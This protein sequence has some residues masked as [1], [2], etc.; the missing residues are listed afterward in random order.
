MPN[1]N[2]LSD[3]KRMLDAE[4]FADFDMETSDKKVIKAHKGVL[5]SRS[6]VF[7]GMLSSGMKETKYNI[8]KVPEDSVVMEEVLRFIYGANEV[9]NMNAI[10]CKLA[11]AAEKY[12]LDELKKLC[13]AHIIKNLSTENVLQAL[14]AADR[15][16]GSEKLKVKCIGMIAWYV[17]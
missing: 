11:F 17:G 13:L 8:V 6:P 2:L 15:L 9:K 3:L 10:A 5:A 16:T 4:L 1:Q 7:Y 14:L 12:Q